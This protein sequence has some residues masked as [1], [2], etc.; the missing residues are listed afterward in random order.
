MRALKWILLVLAVVVVIVQFI[1]PEKNIS[2]EPTSIALAQHFPVPQ[3][4]QSVLQRSCNDCHSNNTVY[5]WYAEIQPLG[6]WL[7][8]QIRDGKRGVNFDEYT[9]YRLMKQYHRFNDIIEQVKEDKMPLPSYLLIH[10]YAKL[11]AEETNFDPNDMTNSANSRKCRWAQ[12]SF[13]KK[14]TIDVE[15]AKVLE[16]DHH[17]PI[18]GK[19]STGAG[20]L[21]GHID[22]DAKG[23]P[24][25]SNP[26]FFPTGAVQGKVTTAA[27]AKEMKIWARM[28]HPCGDDFLAAPFFNKHPEYKWQDKFLVDMKGNPWT[29][30]GAKK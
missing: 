20:V 18:T 9:G 25:W 1:R 15:L 10:R 27:L 16:G 26:P 11:T 6:W 17:D 28:G 21:C 7:N 13:E 3:T 2:K 19:E 14:G 8:K 12:L 29:L 30:F 24:E 23:A 4:I 5:P 22:T